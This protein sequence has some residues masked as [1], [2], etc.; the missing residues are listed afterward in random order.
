MPMSNSDAL[1]CPT[2]SRGEKEE[3]GELQ[4]EGDTHFL[5][6]LLASF[7]KEKVENIYHS[8]NNYWYMF[9]VRNNYIYCRELVYVH[10][11]S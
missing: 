5:F 6:V 2:G 11:T 10:G 8:F 7:L 4:L 3:P 1:Q 9:V